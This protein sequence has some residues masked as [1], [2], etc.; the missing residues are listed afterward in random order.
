MTSEHKSSVTIQ[1]KQKNIKR[2]AFDAEQTVT[3]KQYYDGDIT[4][5]KQIV[6]TWNRQSGNTVAISNNEAAEE[7]NPSGFPP[8]KGYYNE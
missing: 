7:N 4:Q 3:V 2:K 8:T 6:D 1:V 5:A